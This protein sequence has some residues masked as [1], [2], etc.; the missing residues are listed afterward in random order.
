MK[1]RLKGY[2]K[3]T[4]AFCLAIIMVFLLTDNLVLA[5]SGMFERDIE[6][7]YLSKNDDGNYVSEIM[8]Y[9][10]NGDIVLERNP[11]FIHLQQGESVIAYKLV[12]LNRSVSELEDYI[13]EGNVVEELDFNEYREATPSDATPSDATPSNATPSNATPS[14]ATPSDATPSDASFVIYTLGD[15]YVYASGE[16]PFAFFREIF[17]RE[18]FHRV[19]NLNFAFVP[20]IY[21]QPVLEIVR[22]TDTDITYRVRNDENF[23]L[24]YEYLGET[25]RRQGS[26][27]YDIVFHKTNR[28]G[29]ARLTFKY[30]E[31]IVIGTD[32]KEISAIP[33]EPEAEVIPPTTEPVPLENN[34]TTGDTRGSSAQG[35]SLPDTK[36]QFEI[37][38]YTGTWSKVIPKWEFKNIENKSVYYK[39]W[40]TSLGQKE[41][42]RQAV[43][44]KGE[45]IPIDLDGIYI[46]KVWWE[47]EKGNKYDE[48]TK[49]IKIDR[50]IPQIE[51]SYHSEHISNNAYFNKDVV[52]DIKITEGNFDASRVKITAI[53]KKSGRRFTPEYK[54]T[55][56]NGV[57]VAKVYFKESGRYSIH[58]DVSDSADRQA[59]SYEGETVIL[60][61]KNPELR[62]SGVENLSSN[63]DVPKIQIVYADE[64][65]D[66]TRTYIRLKSMSSK[67][68]Y[69]LKGK[70][71]S[72][73]GGYKIDD[74][75]KLE[76]DTYVLEAGIYDLAGNLTSKSLVFSVNT[77]GAT[78]L[79]KPT[80]LIG[81]YTN[82]DF[83]PRIEVWNT[84]EV[85][86]ISATINGMEEEYDYIDGE[87]VFKKE[88]SKEGKYIFNLEVLDTAGNKSNM[89]TVELILDKTAPVIVV[90]GIE[91]GAIYKE[92]VDLIVSTLNKQDRIQSILLN[93]E[94]FE[95]YTELKDGS[96]KLMLS[97]SGDYKLYLEAVDKAG[98]ISTEEVGFM[99]EDSKE[100]SVDYTNRTGNRGI[101][102]AVLS[103][104][105]IGTGFG[106]YFLIKKRK[107]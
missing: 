49:E 80:E 95:N 103:L 17:D 15:E 63:K 81:E 36:F 41:S 9:D 74:V 86:I 33:S 96:K 48:I 90:D 106:A 94:V 66:R 55:G 71:D 75:G 62:I 89:P 57:H 69:E 59:E 97:K 101:S 99:I 61:L 1:L 30:N 2:W 102:I 45:N 35:E 104:L 53:D 84:E 47:D 21:K 11:D 3:R 51:V 43:L 18:E 76:D 88:I 32:V 98:N 13:A 14:N 4:V 72:N 85:S 6:L 20:I 107:K 10:D 91:K 27:S 100:T 105:V 34:N 77:K 70:A 93:G 40:N 44:Y 46:V 12:L 37:K 60:D 23:V 50:F 67:R 87:L 58:V 79:F 28:V 16:Y 31:D 83:V 29:Q 68:K 73:V 42:L 39:I 7:S 82:K 5:I 54:F 52:A 25:M 8:I 19:R 56:S 38:G 78:F 22:E 92:K 64:N 65:I 24:E 26:N